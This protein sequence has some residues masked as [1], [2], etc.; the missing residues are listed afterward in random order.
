MKNGTPPLPQ[1]KIKPMTAEEYTARFKAEKARLQ[2]AYCDIFKLWRRCRFK[3][4]RKA[5]ACRG[6]AHACLERG[7]DFVPRQAQWDARQEIMKSSPETTGR[8]ERTVRQF[9]PNDFYAVRG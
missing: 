1:K 9:M 7:L 2:R 3:P 5:R 6:D 4:C 8:A